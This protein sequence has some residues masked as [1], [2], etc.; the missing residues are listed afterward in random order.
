MKVGVFYVDKNRKRFVMDALIQSIRDAGDEITCEYGDADVVIAFGLTRFLDIHH[1]AQEDNKPNVLIDMGYWE[2]NHDRY[3][4]KNYYRISMKH[5][6]PIDYIMRMEE[7]GDRFESFGRAIRPWKRTR[8]GPHILLADIGQ[9]SYNFFGMEYQSWSKAAAKELQHY[10]D[11]PIIYRPKLSTSTPTGGLPG[12]QFS[13]PAKEP[14][15]QALSGAH[16]IVT[17]HSNAACNA[18]LQG[19]PVF[20]EKGTAKN[21]GLQNLSLIEN[22]YY[23][24]NR[25][26]FFHNLAYC[27]WNVDEMRE[28]LTWRHI[29]ER[30]I[31]L[32]YG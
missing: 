31:P 26:T 28:G 6:H 4:P 10:T 19:I 29:K 17:Y 20:I 21:M 5:P 30:L 16:A 12:F 1:K 15:E 27:Q 25:E 14:I 7:K 9:K 32:I 13:N 23:P 8:S 22:P 3:S 2:R 18:L 11:R 24:A